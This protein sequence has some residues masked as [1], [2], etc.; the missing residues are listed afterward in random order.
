MT[1]PLCEMIDT[2]PDETLSEVMYE[3]SECRGVPAQARMIDPDELRARAKRR[4][5][6]LAAERPF[7]LPDYRAGKGEAYGTVLRWLDE[8]EGRG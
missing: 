5:S 1:F 8:L 2:I 3:V 7:V 4:L 6:E